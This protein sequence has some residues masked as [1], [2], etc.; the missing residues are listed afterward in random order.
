MLA[1]IRA[2][3]WRISHLHRRTKSEAILDGEL[4]F[5][6]QMEIEQNLR[7]GMSPEEARRQAHIAL[8]GLEQTREECR[9]VLAVRLLRDLVQDL[10]YGLRQLRHAPGFAG[11]AAVTLALG[12]GAN[13]AVFSVIQVVLLRPLPYRDASRIVVLEGQALNTGNFEKWRQ[14]AHSYDGFA[15]MSI[16]IGLVSGTGEPI[17]IRTYEVS[18]DFFPV[19]GVQPAQGR[20]FID[21]DFQAGSQEVILISDRLRHE[22]LGSDQNVL[23]STISFEGRPHLVIGMIP[24]NCPLPA[25]NIDAW[26]PMRGGRAK[27][28]AV[29]A[30]LRPG[31][32]FSAAQIEDQSLATRFAS[33][34]RVQTNE[35]LIYSDP[36]L[37][38]LVGNVQ[39]VLLILAGAIAFVLL[40]ACANVANLCLSRMG[41]RRRE[42]AVR[43]ALGASRMRLIRQLL[44]ESLLLAFIG[45]AGG[46]L[47][48]HWS[49]TLFVS[50]SPYYIPRID[51]AGMDV[52]VLAFTSCIA[53]FTTL[54]FGLIPALRYARLDVQSELK[55][56]SQRISANAGDRRLRGALAVAEIAISLVLLVGAALLI[57]TFLV[58]RPSDPGFDP[59]GKLTMRVGLGSSPRMPRNQQVALAR[60]ALQKLAGISGIQGAAFVSDLPMTGN[61]WIPDIWAGQQQLAG[62]YS[63][64]VHCRASTEGFFRLM[65]RPIV[66]GRDFTAL[67]DEH[68]PR[69]A[70]VCQV[71]ARRFWPDSDA[72]G[73][74]ITIDLGGGEK[75][76]TTIVGVVAEARVSTDPIGTDP[77]I[78]LPL[79]QAGSRNPYLV[80]SILGD[81][82]EKAGIIRQ[83][84][85]SIEPRV[86]FDD[87]Q[88]LD[89]ILADSVAEPRFQSALLGVLA[90][91]AFVLA[92][93]GI[94]GVVS[95]TVTL[96]ARELG[97]R[98][99]LGARRAGVMA[100]V[101]RQ[102]VALIAGGVLCGLLGA[103]A[104]TRLL[105][106]VLYGTNPMD[107]IAFAC[108]SIALALVAA[109]AC[110]VAA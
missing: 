90:A 35:A 107:P 36:L 50:L 22:I 34:K 19:L 65:K 12:I 44:V 103:F 20:A 21:S 93:I 9:E 43:R 104:T 26:L 108:A 59:H 67:D 99:A 63:V 15:A 4:K 74:R 64:W 53:I 16:G 48:A 18:A 42:I 66:R 109:A 88:T 8:G 86:V 92:V 14:S 58:L 82:L 85:R 37:E 98:L 7:Q 31:I 71:T 51:E 101:M 69:V 83:V 17:R 84:I 13:T 47:V 11:V 46:L 55:E 56:G 102:G 45:A 105:S 78:Y 54:I 80:A 97:I 39:P 81:P 89:Q 38:R 33:G 5:H 106:N 23:D 6:L 73:R 95:Y 100:L 24:R 79:A 60:S 61:S 30:R 28:T 52:R 110:A 41:T 10:S 76:E 27:G 77:E 62:R 1:S 32:G 91:L 68:A 96:R 57:K 72:V 40:I 75:A 29:L 49:V 25:S 2:F 3:L 94:Y 87:V 70:I